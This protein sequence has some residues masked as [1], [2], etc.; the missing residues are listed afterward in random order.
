M[1]SDFIKIRLLLKVTPPAYK[2]FP[3]KQASQ[4]MRQLSLSEMEGRAILEVS[5]C[6]SIID[7]IAE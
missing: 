7:E 5:V 3:M 4:V 1:A 2:V 6:P